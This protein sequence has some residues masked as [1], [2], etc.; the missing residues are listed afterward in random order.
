MNASCI[1]FSS[2][3]IAFAPPLMKTGI[4]ACRSAPTENGSSGDQITSPRYCDSARSIAFSRP[5]TTPGP[6]AWT[7][8]LIDKI[9]TSA[10]CPDSSVHRRTASSSNTVLPPLCPLTD[11]SPASG[12]RNS[13]L[14]YT[15]SAERAT[16]FFCDGDHEPSGVCTPPAFATGPSNTHFGSGTLASA[17]PASMSAFTHSAIC[18]QPAACHV[19][20]GPVDQPKP[21]RSAKSTS[22]AVSAIDSACTAM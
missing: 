2:A 20:N 15:G 9:R 7:L 10:I 18:F 19:S 17:S 5:L 4:I 3:P 6:I 22:R 16:N 8:V 13:C 14:P 11:V 21:Q 12:A 1:F